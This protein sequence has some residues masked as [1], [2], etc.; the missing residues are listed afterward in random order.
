MS[1]ARW[2]WLGILVAASLAFEVVFWAV[3][4]AGLCRAGFW[5]SDLLDRWARR[6]ALG[7]TIL[8]DDSMRRFPR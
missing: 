7:D 5:L 6:D 4:F 8:G 1:R 3:L 2:F